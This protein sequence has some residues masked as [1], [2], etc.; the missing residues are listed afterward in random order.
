MLIYSIVLSLLTF[1]LGIILGYILYQFSFQQSILQVNQINSLVI[2]AQYLAESRQL[3]CTNN[4]FSFLQY[5]KSE[6]A[7]VGT[8]LTYLQ[9]KENLYY[10]KGEVQY[11]KSQYFNLE[12]LQFLLT[13]KYIDTCNYNNFTLI[14]YFYNNNY[15]STE[16]D[17][18]G[19]ILS[20][21]YANNEKSLYIYSFDSSYSNYFI[22]YYDVEYNITSWPYIVIIK[23]NNTYVFNKF[24]NLTT[25][26][27]YV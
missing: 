11:L 8:E 3:E 25:L 1:F 6:I 14:L 26:E 27:N 13:K 16:C 4:Y 7:Q 24:V 2:S 19:E 21:L 15:C 18:E 9:S 5:L 20:Y 10:N 22:Q 12:Y 23:N 17:Q